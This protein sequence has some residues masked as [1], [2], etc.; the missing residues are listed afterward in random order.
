MNIPLIYEKIVLS[1]FDY[2]LLKK[3]IN[4][5]KAVPLKDFLNYF[6]KKLTANA[7]G[8]AWTTIA[9]GNS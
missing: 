1:L 9:G 8:P 7:P 2:T 6:P 3:K 5:L 4:F